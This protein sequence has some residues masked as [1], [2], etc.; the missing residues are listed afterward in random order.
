M[1]SAVGF[2]GW[3]QLRCSGRLTGQLLILR[4]MTLGFWRLRRG[5][6]GSA[7]ISATACRWAWLLFWGE[8][9][10]LC[11]GRSTSCAEAAYER[12]S[13]RDQVGLE[14]GVVHQAPD[15]VVG[16]EVP[17]RFLVDPVRGSGAQDDFRAT[18]VGFQFV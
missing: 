12:Q 15:R 18:L 4:L 13:V 10:R 3:G 17:P 16:R 2:D 14:R 6:S 5:G 11:A 1:A 8:K 9:T 7:M